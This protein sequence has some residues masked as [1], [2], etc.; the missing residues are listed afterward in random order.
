MLMLVLQVGTSST[1]T[2]R[3]SARHPEGERKLQVL[4]STVAL[5]L[6]DSRTSLN[7]SDLV[8]MSSLLLHQ[9]LRHLTSTCRC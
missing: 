8:S 9:Q 1:V 3:R 4:L 6:T 2:L 7:D 5:L